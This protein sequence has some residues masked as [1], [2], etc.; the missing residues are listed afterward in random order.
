M[1]CNIYP[2]KRLTRWSNFHK[3][4]R[5]FSN[6]NESRKY[7]KGDV[8]KSLLL[9]QE[10]RLSNNPNKYLEDKK[11]FVHAISDVYNLVNPNELSKEDETL[12]DK[13]YEEQI[14]KFINSAQFKRL[15][16]DKFQLNN[17]SNAVN[18]SLMISNFKTLTS[19]EYDAVHKFIID[20]NICSKDW[21][22]LPLYIKQLQYFMAYGPL[23]PRSDMRFDESPFFLIKPNTDILSR[24]ILGTFVL[25]SSIGFIKYEFQD[26]K[27]LNNQ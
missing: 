10:Q 26:K 27:K 3:L 11:P 2:W 23:G 16:M 25:I 24:I 15:L 18:I 9:K 8:P 19:M 22:T 13:K 7:I 20:P 17:S 21:K 4:K 14:S 1:Q 5:S 12:F 6:P